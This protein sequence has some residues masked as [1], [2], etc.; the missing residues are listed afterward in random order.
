MWRGRFSAILVLAVALMLPPGLFRDCCC[1]RRVAAEP[2]LTIPVRA[3]CQAKRTELTKATSQKVAGLGLIQPRC[4]CQSQLANIAILVSDQRVTASSAVV[5]TGLPFSPLSSF[6]GIDAGTGPFSMLALSRSPLA[7][8]TV[9][10][11]DL[12]S[13]RLP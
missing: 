8:N 9:Q 7:Q 4:Q 13:S 1:T 3:C 10:V 11:G 12:I 6:R 2:K 5:M